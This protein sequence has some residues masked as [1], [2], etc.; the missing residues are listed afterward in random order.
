M[1]V[2]SE[3]DRDFEAGE[4]IDI[5]LDINGE[6]QRDE[7][8]EYMLED[9]NA[10]TQQENTEVQDIRSSHDDDMADDGYV[11][12]LIAERYSVHDEDLEDAEYVEPGV[13]EDTIVQAEIEGPFESYSEL[14]DN[15]EQN[16]A[17]EPKVQ[18]YQEQ[19]IDTS[20]Q[21]DDTPYHQEGMSND[22]SE[23]TTGTFHDERKGFLNNSRHVSPPAVTLDAL[24][25]DNDNGTN[26][27]PDSLAIGDDD[28][29]TTTHE[30][31][32]TT[33]Q[34]I[35]D[36][37]EDLN[38]IQAEQPANLEHDELAS[39]K[40]LRSEQEMKA[41]SSSFEPGSQ[42]TE[43]SVT[44]DE[45][46]LKESYCIHPVTVIY[47]DNE[48]S[49]FPPIGHEEDRSSTYFL[50]DEQLANESISKLL[51]ACRTVL[52]ESISTQEELIIELEE[53]GLQLGEVSFSRFSSYEI[54]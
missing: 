51:G 54:R 26:K 34:E 43:D 16:E 31:P 11:E 33:H 7:E 36:K 21:L 18:A 9:K 48:I 19:G 17:G 38:F 30:I 12:G 37:N 28:S 23:A 15:E 27:P 46:D 24:H 47:Q 4:D 6:N 29:S 41:P 1:E 40:A 42:G 22:H 35:L 10:L 50:Q 3:M 32:Y 49:L 14:F 39:A 45:N 8:D 5:D 25:Q 44:L 53:L 20:Q 13:N 2:T 52:G